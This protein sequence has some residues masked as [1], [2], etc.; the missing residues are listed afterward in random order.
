MHV[1]N[2]SIY[3]LIQTYST[4]GNPSKHGR[5]L[6]TSRSMP[7]TWSRREKEKGTVDIAKC[8]NVLVPLAYVPRSCHGWPHTYMY[9]YIYIS[10]YIYIYS[11]IPTYR[12]AYKVVSTPTRLRNIHACTVPL[13]IFRIRA[14]MLTMLL[15]SSSF[16]KS[17]SHL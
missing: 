11:Y 7:R 13:F 2:T 6:R 8:A 9:I 17:G 15:C 16:L 14:C 5:F 4:G 12:N 10:N 3:T 1:R